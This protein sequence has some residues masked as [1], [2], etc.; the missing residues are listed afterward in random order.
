MD[1]HFTLTKKALKIFFF[2]FYVFDKIY[3]CTDAGCT[4]QT[5]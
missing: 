3:K 1:N 5:V 2:F 4:M